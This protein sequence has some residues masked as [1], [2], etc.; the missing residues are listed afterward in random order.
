[1]SSKE[2]SQSFLILPKC[3]Y[4]TESIQFFSIKCEFM[5]WFKQFQ[6]ANKFSKKLS[7]C[8]YYWR[9]RTPNSMCTAQAKSL[10]KSA[11]RKLTRPSRSCT[12]PK[13][14]VLLYK[15]PK[16][17]Y[18]IKVLN[19]SANIQQWRQPMMKVPKV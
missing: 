15:L 19:L 1:M 9:C 3:V 8:F 4:V 14:I 2:Q 16:S 11:D 6:N 13:K 18:K 10:R 7:T 12:H 5:F 17:L